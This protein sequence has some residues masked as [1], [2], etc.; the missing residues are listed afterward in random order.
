VPAARRTKVETRLGL[1]EY[2]GGIPAPGT[3]KKMNDNVDFLRAM[4]V[5]LNALAGVS[6]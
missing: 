5:Y 4:P 2:R 1:R 3:V 6:T